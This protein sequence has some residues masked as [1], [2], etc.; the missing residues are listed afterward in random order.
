ML[1]ITVSILPQRMFV[2][3]IGAEHVEVNVMVLPGE[4][5]A[6]YEPTSA[7]L[8]ALSG[9]DAYISIGV[10]FEDVWLDRFHGL[11]EDMML[12]DTTQGVER[13]GDADA[14]DPHIWLSPTL[15]K[16]QAR[17]IMEALTALDP[18]HADDYQAN[19]EA[20][21]TDIDVLDG[22]IRATLAGV[23]RRRFMV[24]H[25]SWAYF[26]RDYELEMIPIEVG[27]QEPSAGELAELVARAEEEDVRVIFAQ[28]EFST[29]AAEAIADE[30]GGEVLLISP[31]A[32]DWLGNL[33]RVAETFAE[34]LGSQRGGMAGPTLE[35]H[36]CS[37]WRSA[38][39]YGGRLAFV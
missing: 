25:P 33:R 36:S 35:V 38:S 31:L 21:V 37:D 20:L 23:E 2:E 6:T 1:R 14:P 9:A 10:P 29:Q 26:A 12:V 30:I 27:G 18:V 4:S 5:P 17:T 19:L 28:P 15:V 24:F 7:Q 13:I 32:E 8:K 39:V 22:D 3:R 16:V 34:Y 11:N